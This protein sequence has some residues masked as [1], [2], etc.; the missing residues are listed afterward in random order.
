MRVMPV[1]VER[2]KSE[3]SNLIHSQYN[4]FTIQSSYFSHLLSILLLHLSP[5]KILAFKYVST[6]IIGF[7]LGIHR[8]A[9]TKSQGLTKG[10]QRIFQDEIILPSS[11]QIKQDPQTKSSPKGE[12]EEYPNHIGFYKQF[13]HWFAN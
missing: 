13:E 12:Q 1:T 7:L 4:S 10:C 3:R 11:T 8:C 2:M 9:C 6:F 5:S